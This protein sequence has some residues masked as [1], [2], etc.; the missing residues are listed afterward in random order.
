MRRRTYS[1]FFV[2]FTSFIITEAVGQQTNAP[3][4][5]KQIWLDF[6]PQYAINPKFVLY[7]DLDVRTIF[8]QSW[9]RFIARGGIAY[10]QKLFFDEKAEEEFHAGIGF[11]YTLNF[12]DPN[13][14]EI[15]PY[16]GYKLQWPHFARLT[17]QNFVRLEERFEYTGDGGGEN[18]GL[19]LRYQIT[20]T[21][22]CKNCDNRFIK[23]FYLLLSDEFFFNLN[24]TDQ[25]NDLVRVG[26]GLGYHFPSGWRPEFDLTFNRTRGTVDEKLT[27]S[28]LVF[29]LRV[30]YKIPDKKTKH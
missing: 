15:R 6:N 8:P 30:F 4:I 24:G 10:K 25:F 17:V 19:R 28:D 11:F 5:T 7:G 12:N 9:Y 23:P 18:F 16:Q 22:R 3:A 27:T 13:R 20:G 1:F 26:P 14:F 2:L 29:R 21:L